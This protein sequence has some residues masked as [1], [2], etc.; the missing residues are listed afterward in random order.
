VVRDKDPPMP[1]RR[2]PAPELHLERFLPYR[3]S[4]LANT[5]SAAIAS[6]YAER[7]D[8][9]IPEWRIIAVLAQDPGLTAAEVAARTAMDK[10]AVSR[11]VARLELAGRVRRSAV[12]DDRRRQQLALTREGRDVYTRIVPWAL[13]YERRLLEALDP[14]ALRALDDALHR[15]TERAQAEHIMQN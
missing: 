11:A 10:V 12:R 1:R 2:K 15:L 13:E 14:D 9:T 7:H 6:V 5:V 8:L 3:L 4:V